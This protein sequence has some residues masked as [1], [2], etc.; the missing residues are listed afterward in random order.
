M[1]NDIKT[2]IEINIDSLYEVPDASLLAKL[3]LRH[4]E[5][6]GMIP[7]GRPIIVTFE[8]PFPTSEHLLN[9]ISTIVPMVAEV[10]NSNTWEPEE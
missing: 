8:E 4:I 6:Y 3:I 5:E 10:Q 9:G 2:L 1:I 7:P